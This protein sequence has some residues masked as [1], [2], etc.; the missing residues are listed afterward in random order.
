M[1][2]EIVEEKKAG[3]SGA[4]VGGLAGGAAGALSMV[5]ASPLGRWVLL[6]LQDHWGEDLQ[7][8]VYNVSQHN[9][10]LS[11][12]V[13]EAYNVVTNTILAYPYILPIATGLI[14]A[15][16]GALIGKKIAKSKLKHKSLSSKN[17]K[18]LTM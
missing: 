6:N 8:L 5:Q 3:K 10:A 4:L 1:S 2:E 14:T 11:R 9:Y 17:T 15:A 7:E 18:S 13:Q 12:S 16:A